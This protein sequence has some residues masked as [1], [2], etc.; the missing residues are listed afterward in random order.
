MHD[1]I[2]VLRKEK[3]FTQQQAADYLHLDRS[4]YAYYESGRS[5]LNANLI[6]KLAHFYQIRYAVLLGVPEPVQGDSL[7]GVKNAFL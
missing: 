6:V 1:I 2:R 5:K 3:G 4:T 7:E